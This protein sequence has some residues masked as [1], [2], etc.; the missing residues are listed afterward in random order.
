MMEDQASEILNRLPRR[1]GDVAKP[2]AERSPDHAAVAERSG[3]WT[4]G[5]LAAAVEDTQ[6]WLS[7]L[8]VRPGDRVMLICENCRAFGAILLA[9]SGLDAWPVLVN[10]HLSRREVDK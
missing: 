7:E 9:L 2:R 3:T 5:Q 1:I 8:G 6:H 10:A 4:Y